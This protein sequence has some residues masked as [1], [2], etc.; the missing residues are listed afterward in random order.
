MIIKE[1]KSQD[2]NKY[3]DTDF[4][5]VLAYADFCGTCQIMKPELEALAESRDD[6]NLVEI[7]IDDNQE[8]VI[9]KKIAG[10]PV[11]YIYKNG[12]EIKTIP[13]FLPKEEI[14]KELK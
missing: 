4:T 11:T 9:E 12:K 14:A 1:A 6:L 2:I 5:I 8:F 13:G 7:K 10:T 3:M